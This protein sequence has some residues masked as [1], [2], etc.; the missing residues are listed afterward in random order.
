MEAVLEGDF[1]KNVIPVMYDGY[2]CAEKL[3]DLLILD[4]SVS[5][6]VKAHISKTFP[7]STDKQVA[8]VI[9]RLIYFILQRKFIKHGSDNELAI[10]E[11]QDP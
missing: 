1:L 8:S 11:G 6:M 9:G 5:G 7:C 10:A 4:D 3:H 2:M